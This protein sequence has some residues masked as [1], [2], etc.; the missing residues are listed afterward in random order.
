MHEKAEI[1]DMGPVDDFGLK[2]GSPEWE[3]HYDKPYHIQFDGVWC[4]RPFL[5]RCDASRYAKKRAKTIE[6]WYAI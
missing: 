6:H 4:K 2:V 3:E 1:F 5:R